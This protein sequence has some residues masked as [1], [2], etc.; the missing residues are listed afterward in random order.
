MSEEEVKQNLIN[1]Y[2]MLLQIKADEK[3]ENRTL[4]FQ[5]ELTKIKLSSY[6]IDLEKIEKLILQK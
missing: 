5:I 2:A 6:N 1:I 3:G 4:D